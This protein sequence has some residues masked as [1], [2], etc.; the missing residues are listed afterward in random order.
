MGETVVRT[1]FNGDDAGGIL[2]LRARYGKIA[3]APKAGKMIFD[4]ELCFVYE[5]NLTGFSGGVVGEA[6]DLGAPNQTGKGRAGY[7][8]IAC[9]QDMT[10][11]GDPEISLSLEFSETES[12]AVPV[13]VPLALPVL[14]K[15]D[16]AKGKVVGAL[17]PLFALRYARLKMDTTATLACAGLTAGFVLDLQTNA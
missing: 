16:F 6:L 3:N 13:T 4:R 1:I 2:G 12:F 8:A 5:G 10:A 9:Q 14:H 7:V 11:T 17:A 15:E